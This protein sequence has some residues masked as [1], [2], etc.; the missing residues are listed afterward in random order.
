MTDS[1]PRKSGY[2]LP[3]TC[4]DAKGSPRHHCVCTATLV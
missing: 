2:V 4:P 1:F 3:L